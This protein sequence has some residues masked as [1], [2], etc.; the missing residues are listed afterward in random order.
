MLRRA[1]LEVDGSW[2]S[3]DGTELGEGSR[4]ILRALKPD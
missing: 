1:G 3:W 4:T 2:G